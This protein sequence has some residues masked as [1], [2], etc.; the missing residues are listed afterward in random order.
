LIEQSHDHF[1]D[2]VDG[3]AQAGQLVFCVVSIH[4]KKPLPAREEVRID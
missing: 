4:N 1:I 3:I 2:A